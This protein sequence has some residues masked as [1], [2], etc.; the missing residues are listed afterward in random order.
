MG[1]GTRLDRSNRSKIASGIGAPDSSTR[2][3]IYLDV[4]SGLLYVKSESAWYVC[5]DKLWNL[6]GDVIVNRDG[7]AVNITTTGDITLSGNNLT[8]DDQYLSAAI[9]IS[10]SGTTGLVGFTTATSIVGALNE[11]KVGAI[12]LDVAYNNSGGASNVA[13]DAGDLTWTVSKTHSHVVDITGVTN[14]IDGFKVEHT[15]NSKYFRLLPDTDSGTR[16]ELKTDLYR[17]DIDTD[18]ALTIDSSTTVSID[19][20]TSSNF[21]VSG[22]TSDL[23][24]G[25]RGATIT[26]NQSGDTSLSGFTATSLVGCLNE[27]KGHTKYGEIQIIDNTNSATINASDEWHSI[28]GDVATGYVSGF[29]YEAGSNGVIASIADA[30]GGQITVGDVGHGLSAGDMITIN[31]CTDSAY[32]GLFEV[33]TVPTADTFTV[34]ATYTAT[35]TGTWQKG[36]NLTCDSGSAGNYS[37]EWSAAGISQTINEVFD[38][39]PGINTTVFSKAKARRKFSNVDYGSF[40]G[41]GLQS[42]NEGDKIFFVCQNVG[43]SGN[44]TIRTLNLHMHK[45]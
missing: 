24:L 26:L 15:T 34:T 40:S 41:C 7:R 11:L 18:S 14:T 23:T 35:D 42:I 1:T 30:G 21:T 17:I 32:N 29:T 3:N 12:T 13:V 44:I 45:I 25:A 20:A 16:M 39:A 8:F 27:L 19:A 37:I 31:G 10:Q 43:A 22:A 6:S 9:P 28:Y 36:A 2:G 4:S 33:I 38:F 5:G